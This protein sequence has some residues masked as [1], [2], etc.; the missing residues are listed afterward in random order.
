MA[1]ALISAV[2]D[3]LVPFLAEQL[4]LLTDA[5][6]EFRSFTST[7]EAIR[8]V[9]KDADGKQVQDAYVKRWL[10][11]LKD[12]S[13]DMDAV[14]DEWNTKL[15]E[16]ESEAEAHEEGKKA[17]KA[18]LLKKLVC[19][20]RPSSSSH[21]NPIKQ[22][23]V[24]YHVAS[25]IKELNGRLDRIADEKK[26][27]NFVENPIAIE[28]VQRETT[29]FKD[30][31]EVY[32]R[33]VEKQI[34]IEK[35]L[36]ESSKA[37]KGFEVI[38][39]V[40]MGGIG[41]TS[42]AQL[43]YNEDV[44]INHFNKR[45]WV[46]AT[47][48]FDVVMVARAIAQALH[49]GDANVIA[50]WTFQTLLERIDEA[51]DGKKFFLVVD[52]VWTDDHR[53]WE[54]LEEA[55]RKGAL[56]SRILVTT[57]KTE[58]AE[59][60]RAKSNMITL[61][62]LSEEVC[63]TIFSRLAFS[64]GDKR[65]D[66]LEQIGRQIVQKCKG[67]PLAA[68]TLGSLMSFKE[69][70]REDWNY[71][72]KSELWE[73]KKF[74]EQV[75]IPLMLSYYDLPPLE[76]RCFLFC[77]Y[78]P[79]DHSIGRDDL[80]Q[81]WLS[82]GYLSSKRNYWEQGLV[83]FRNLAKRSLFQDFEED[84]LGDIVEC[85]MHDIVHDFALFLTENEFFNMKL[86]GEEIEINK[87]ARHYTLL[88]EN[89]AQLPS[90][91]Y[92]KKNLRAL[93]VQNMCSSPLS[94]E[95]LSNS[96]SSVKTLTLSG[97]ELT[98]VPEN[99]D[100]LIYLRYLNLSNN[101]KLSILPETLCNLVNLQTLKLDGCSDIGRLP[102]GIGKLASLRHLHLLGSAAQEIPKSLRE[103]TNLQTLDEFQ[104]APDEKEA[105]TLD[106]LN[107]LNSLRGSIWISGM[108]KVED[109]SEAEKAQLKNKGHLDEL[110]L[111]FGECGDKQ[112]TALLE[113]LQPHPNLKSLLIWDYYGT[114]AFPSWMISSV[115]LKRLVLFD[116]PACEV[117]PP[118]GKLQSLESLHIRVM[119]KVERVG[120]EFL[121][122]ESHAH[123]TIS[124][125]KLKH[126]RFTELWNWK[127]WEGSREDSSS[128]IIMPC[129]SSLEIEYCDKLE[130]LPNFLR[131]TPLKNLTT[132]FCQILEDK[133]SEYVNVE[134][135]VKIL[136]SE[137]GDGGENAETWRHE[138]RV[139]LTWPFYI[140]KLHIAIYFL[141]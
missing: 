72:L 4:S 67:L 60:M 1:E 36:R 6:N 25:R 62:G 106:D 3:Q 82:Q 122:I 52:D 102:K 48:P 121:G 128:T 111:G 130:A 59:M 124:F 12:V 81:L 66:E 53:K 26:R 8:A 49:P 88:L 109:A 139:V 77:S 138:E 78:F 118:F 68:K 140:S 86:N 70:T 79:K 89:Q 84:E 55:L 113:V 91:V 71:V 13:Y 98:H 94:F 137:S 93:F 134:E 85:K 42:L 97:C 76:K 131:K 126:L 125:P 112:A 75:F 21:S 123:T 135:V 27:Y 74:E 129:L 117:L 30:I 96:T 37:Q 141:P 19:C 103:L 73:L 54:P 57:R 20:F 80:I 69:P 39:V 24:R 9:L 38:P 31:S 92:Q 108:G 11:Q 43:V 50:H 47:D 116:C 18:I 15:G 110:V 7:L 32:G 63:W 65:D 95:S 120:G 45:I 46:Y 5:E 22:V 119:K 133:R 10:D 64:N 105:M 17:E 34:V 104:L 127:E 87:K 28:P 56:G 115:N 107:Q 132:K 33:D 99:I 14:L 51:I 100:K 40:G 101:T 44:V 90:Q 61:A 2:L 29:S 35:L 114:T 136:T 16:E 58:V 41:K 23:G 83:C